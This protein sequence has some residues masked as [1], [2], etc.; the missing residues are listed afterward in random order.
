MQDVVHE[1]ERGCS[2]LCYGV[3]SKTIDV[4]ASQ[5]HVA[6]RSFYACMNISLW[7]VFCV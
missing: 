4:S 2:S 7:D 6:S 3:S 1:Y 5:K